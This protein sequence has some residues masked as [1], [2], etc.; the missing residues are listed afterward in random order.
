MGRLQ[1]KHISA[2]F[3]GQTL[4]K[5]RFCEKKKCYEVRNNKDLSMSRDNVSTII[6]A[7]CPLGSENTPSNTIHFAGF[8]FFY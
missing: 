1:R 4:Q 8:A 3:F 7:G 2:N 6:A 5:T